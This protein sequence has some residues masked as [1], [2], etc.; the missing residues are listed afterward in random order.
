MGR[1]TLIQVEEAQ[2]IP[3]RRNSETHTNQT[4]KN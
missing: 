4:D 1:K 2:R 3:P